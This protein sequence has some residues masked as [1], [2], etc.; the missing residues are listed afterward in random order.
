MEIAPQSDVADPFS[1]GRALVAIQGKFGYIDK[2]GTF[3]INPQYVGAGLF[4]GDRAPV[5]VNSQWGYIDRDGKFA[6]NPQFETPVNS[7]TA[8]PV[9]DTR[10][11]SVTSTRTEIW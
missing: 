4:S 10:T 1:D 6:V 2:K 9:W 7:P 5:S 8:A 3:V 11:A